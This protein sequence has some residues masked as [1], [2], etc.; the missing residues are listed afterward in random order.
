M[1]KDP[2]TRIQT[3]EKRL[4]RTAESFD[5]NPLL[6]LLALARHADA[7]VVHSA[8]WA[9]HRVFIQVIGDGRVGRA[10][11][12]SS[13]PSGEDGVEEVDMEGEGWQVREWIMRRLTEYVDVLAGLM[14]DSEEALRVS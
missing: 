12:V 3:L 2:T 9:L 13:T 4:S 8:I 10:T 11:L 5:P 6:E 14:C 7:R 1:A